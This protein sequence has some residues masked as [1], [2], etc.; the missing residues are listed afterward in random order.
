MPATDALSGLSPSERSNVRHLMIKGILATDMTYHFSL[1]A[2]L[3][4]IILNLNNSRGSAAAS[5]SGSEANSDDDASDADDAKPPNGGGGGGDA[6]AAAK[7]PLLES[8]ADREVLF[9][10]LLH[11]ADISNPA[12][13]W[14]VS[15]RWSDLVLDEAGRDDVAHKDLVS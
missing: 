3:D 12:K 8:D 13:P 14:A 5:R 2:E 10:V 11:T 7:Q 4:H 15:K 1:K 9:K 6:M